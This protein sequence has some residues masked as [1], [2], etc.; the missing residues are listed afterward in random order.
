MKKHFLTYLLLLVGSMISLT[1]C[2]DEVYKPGTEPSKGEIRGKLVLSLTTS[3]VSD[4][5][6]TVNVERGGAIKINHLW[7]GAFNVN[8][9]RCMGAAIYPEPLIMNSGEVHKNLFEIDFVNNEAD[10]PLAYIVAIAN[11]E[12]VTTWDGTPLVDYLPDGYENRSKINWQ[13]IVDLDINT[14]SAYAGEKG[15]DED[16]NAPFLM[17]YFQD[18]VNLSAYP[19]INQFEYFGSNPTPTAIYPTDARDGM[20]IELGDSSDSNVYVAA[21]AIC[22]RRLVAHNEVNINLGP[23]MQV[24]DIMYKRYNMPRVVFMTQRMNDTNYYEEGRETWAKYSSNRADQLLPATM[25]EDDEA[26]YLDPTF[27]Y[28]ADR[29]WI[30]VEGHTFAFDHFENKQWG[31]GTITSQ[32]DREQKN[33][34]GRTYTALCHGEQDWYRNYSSYFVIKMHVV[35]TNKGETADVEYVVHEGFCNTADGKVTTGPDRFYDF[36]SFRNLNYIYTININGISNIHHNATSSAGEMGHYNGQSGEIWQMDY[37]TG[38]AEEKIGAEGG[39][40]TKPGFMKFSANPDLGFRLYGRDEDGKIVDICYNVP[41]NMYDGFKGLW[42]TDKTTRVILTDDNLL[43]AQISSKVLKGIAIVNSDGTDLDI[44]QFIYGIKNGTYS[45]AESYSVRFDSYDDVFLGVPRK[46]MR[47]LYVFDLNDD[48]SFIHDAEG[49]CSIR[50]IFAAEQYPECLP[51]ESVSFDA[52]NIIWHHDWYDYS[53]QESTWCGSENS[54]IPLIWQHDP[55]ITGY[56]L[57]IQN[58]EVP[59]IDMTVTI[60]PSEL[61]RYVQYDEDNDRYIFKYVLSTAKLPAKSASAAYNH[62]LTVTVMVDEDRNTVGEPT[63]VNSCIRTCPSSWDFTSTK[64]WST[65]DFKQ[66]AYPNVE[67]RG[68]RMYTANPANRGSSQTTNPR[69]INFGSGG[70]K[71]DRYFSFYASKPGYMYITVT[72]TGGSEIT[73]GSRPVVMAQ[74][75]E[76]GELVGEEVVDSSTLPQ[77]GDLSRPFKFRLEPGSK[78]TEYRF[79]NRANAHFYKFEFK[80]D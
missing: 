70:S 62:D 59:D 18:A 80:A 11:Y 19:R 78:P 46:F 61:S 56:Q 22:L 4:R 47:A 33:P 3:D 79:Y 77:K 54:G 21:G 63:L 44:C 30:P 28:D 65:F 6:R 27:P 68:L 5:S 58:T 23:G 34:D 39:T 66:N 17:G 15:E 10:L 2:V 42:P 41:E 12:G 75:D 45:T 57:Y 40:F 29:E 60:G 1:S 36:S 16:A 37:V 72:H 26:A 43:S 13:T 74:V 71:D 14:A 20:D 35:D 55:R 64:E 49:C 67:M 69:Y 7:I 38:S 8:T 48:D 32:N 53:T 31:L 24:T 9:G 73:D 25:P 52:S 50:S 76:N 51:L